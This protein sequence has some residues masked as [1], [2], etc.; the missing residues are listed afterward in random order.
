MRNN[1]NKITT[2]YLDK[3][4]RQAADQKRFRFYIFVLRL[5]NPENFM[6]HYKA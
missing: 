6:H 3:L 4:D 2:N 5:V 1:M